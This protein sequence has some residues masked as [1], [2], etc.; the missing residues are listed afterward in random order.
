VPFAANEDWE[1]FLL[2]LSGKWLV[3][4]LWIVKAKGDDVVARIATSA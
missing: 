3:E 2:A 4:W 1:R